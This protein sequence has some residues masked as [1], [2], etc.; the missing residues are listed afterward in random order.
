VIPKI[1]LHVQHDQLDK[2]T[3]VFMTRV[4]C[5]TELTSEDM[6]ECLAVPVQKARGD[7]WR[8]PVLGNIVG[9]FLHNFNP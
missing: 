6:N 9:L 7:R 2:E 1:Y 3:A 8:C 5:R 4:A